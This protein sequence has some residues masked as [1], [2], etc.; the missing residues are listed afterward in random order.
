MPAE[1]PPCILVVDDDRLVLDS[2][3]SPLR[4]C[5]FRVRVAASGEAA[6]ETCRQHGQEIR[7]VLLDV[8]MPGMDGP[9]T[10]AA[11]RQLNPAIRC[12][13]MTGYIEGYSREELLAF[14]ADDFFLKP[15]SIAEVTQILRGLLGESSLRGDETASAS[16]A[17]SRD[18]GSGP[19]RP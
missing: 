14:R 4:Q 17:A 8:R 1:A 2:L 18:T 19:G 12:C 6:L 11:L 10:L 13:F 16:P 7:V 9:Q 3:G 15:V 5:G